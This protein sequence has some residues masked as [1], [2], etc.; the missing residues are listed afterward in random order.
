M[1]TELRYHPISFFVKAYLEMKAAVAVE[2]TVAI[3]AAEYNTTSVDKN[4]MDIVTVTDTIDTS[5]ESVT[6][7]DSDSDEVT[8]SD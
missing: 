1:D 3:E 7:M 2:E 8:C 6:E 4:G 5:A